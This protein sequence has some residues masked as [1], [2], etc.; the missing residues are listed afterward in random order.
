M[1]CGSHAQGSLVVRAHILT[2]LRTKL[3]HLRSF[4][5]ITNTVE[6]HLPGL[7]GTTSHPDMDKIRI[8]GFFFENRLN[9]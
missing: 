5:E 1:R 7:I 8:N 3:L 2:M 6:L 4:I 9:W